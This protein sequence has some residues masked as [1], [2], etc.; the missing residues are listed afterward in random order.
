MIPRKLTE[1]IANRALEECKIY[2]RS[3]GWKSTE[4]MKAYARKDQVGVRLEGAYWLRFQNDGIRPFL[5]T[6]L[7]GKTIPLD[8]HTFRVA[9]GVGEPGYVFI[10]DVKVWRDEKWRHPGITPTK[11]IETGVRKAFRLYRN[12]LQQYHPLVPFRRVGWK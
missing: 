5:M 7:E 4:S 8:K 12:E 9:K 3:R 6:T 1:K 10:D 11:F 2:G